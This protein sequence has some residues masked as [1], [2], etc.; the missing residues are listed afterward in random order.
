[1]FSFIKKKLD[2]NSPIVGKYTALEE[3]PDEAFS[4]GIMGKGFGVLPTENLVFSPIDGEVVMVFPTKH[5]IGI[6]RNDGLE[7]LIHIGIDTVNLKGQGF[8]LLISNDQKIKR[9]QPLVEFNKNFIEENGYNPI[10]IVVFTNSQ[11]FDIDINQS[12][13]SIGKGDVIAYAKRK[14]FIYNYKGYKQ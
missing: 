3:I 10:V 8:K 11:E 2:V 6:K 12:Y 13:S 4:S 5:A 9:G 14:W 7:M 1:V